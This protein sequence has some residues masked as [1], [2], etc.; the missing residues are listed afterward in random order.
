M[1]LG[2]QVVPPARK[3]PRMQEAEGMGSKSLYF[4]SEETGVPKKGNAKVPTP[5]PLQRAPG[6]LSQMAS[7][8]WA[9]ASISTPQEMAY[10]METLCLELVCKTMLGATGQS[11]LEGAQGRLWDRMFSVTTGISFFLL[12]PST[13]A[14]LIFSHLLYCSSVHGVKVT[15]VF[16]RHVPSKYREENTMWSL[17]EDQKRRGEAGF[18]PKSGPLGPSRTPPQARVLCG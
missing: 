2:F 3:K 15:P 7:S 1:A 9:S 5:P 4:L 10:F 6:G 11:P 8:E 12:E 17:S 16:I 18:A 13:P 14:G